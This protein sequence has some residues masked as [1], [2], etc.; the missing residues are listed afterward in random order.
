MT[1][2]GLEIIHPN[3]AHQQRE[4]DLHRDD[5]ARAL[6][7]QMRTGK[8]KAMVDLACYLHRQGRIDG[9]LILAPNN[10][11]A[12]WTR[13][14]IPSHHWLIPHSAMAW[15]TAMAKMASY[16]QEFRALLDCEGLAWYA[17]N[18]EATV[19]ESQKPYLAA[20][21]K[22]R[23]FMLIVDETHEWR[24]PGS[25]RSRAVRLK[26]AKKAVVRRNLSGTMVDNNPMHAWAQYEI[27]QPGALGTATFKEFERRYGVWETD[28]IYI[29]GRPRSIPKLVDFQRMDELRERM[30]AWTSYVYRD[31]CDDMP[32]IVP[33]SVEFEL[34]AEQKRVYNDLVRGVLLSLETGEELDV[35]PDTGVIAKQQMIRSGFI[36]DL[37]GQ[38]H[39]LVE[40]RSNPA[41]TALLELVR[42]TDGKVLV[43]CRLRA[44]I[45]AL[46]RFL[47][48]EGI[49]ALDYYG[50]TK[51][52]SRV[53]NEERFRSDPKVKV[54]VAQ[55]KA[56]G[57]GLDFSAGSHIVW[58]SHIHGDLIGRR[59]ADE[60]CT[61]MGGRKIAVTD[62]VG[63][64]T[65][66]SKILED[67]KAKEARTD[68][69]TGEGLRE[70]LRIVP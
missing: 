68:F 45:E 67:Q 46:L 58:F 5:P 32:A 13:R 47:K 59:Q 17:V 38:V 57:Q 35:D 15:N 42:A 10:V 33:G 22:R 28:D 23:R 11:H 30:A 61:K 12:N 4:F 44:E 64:G 21:M 20:F 49:T 26:I 53:R 3:W 54:M 14:E 37:D 19:L 50:G 43:W 25:K 40:P 63:Q 34:T 6:H 27:L 70:F 69:L 36:R 39:W 52:A 31:E 2:W 55:P 65:V 7:W 48:T 29:G 51:A 9:V 18:A 1:D 62:L 56:C 24:R 8:T 41:F 60:R 66:D 16:D